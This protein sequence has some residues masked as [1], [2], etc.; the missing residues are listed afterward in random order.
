M[1][2]L[3]KVLIFIISLL[4]VGGGVYLL[5]V[6]YAKAPV[7]NPI[8]APV[9]TPA[10]FDPLKATYVIDNVSVAL[11]NGQAKTATASTMVFGQPATGDLNGDG[12]ADAALILTQDTGGSGTFYYAV[13]ALNTA[14]GAQGTNAILLGDRIAPQNIAIESG[15]IIA[16]YADRKPGEPM[17]TPPSVGVSLYLSVNGTTLQRSFTPVQTITYLISPADSTKYCNGVDMDSAGYQKTI[18]TERTTSTPELNTTI[19]QLIKATINAATTGMCREALNQ[20]SITESNGVVTIS[21]LEGWAGVSITMC[22]C[23]PQVEVNL[24]RLPGITKVVW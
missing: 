9:S 20:T 23:K 11:V 14:S 7:V 19:L 3:K 21:P 2:I 17:T 22:S 6:N 8:V 12:L 24:L 16:N 13:A 10:V 5:Y 18:T 1:N 4:L 15:Q